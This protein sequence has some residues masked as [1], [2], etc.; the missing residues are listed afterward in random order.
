MTETRYCLKAITLDL[1]DTLWPSGPALAA[2]EERLHAWLEENAPAVAAALPPP[3]FMQLR[4]ALAAELPLIAHDFTALRHA[5]MTRALALHGEDSALADAGLEVFLA[6]RSEVELY[7]EVLEALERLSKRYRLVALSNGNA[8]IERAGVGRFF[9]AEVNARSAGVAKPDSRIFHAACETVGLPPAQVLHVGDHPDFDVR[10]AAR[11]GLRAA[12][13]NRP[14]AAWAGEAEE[15]HEFHEL[16]ALC[17]W[18][19]A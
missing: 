4:R 19:G 6:A 15:F 16:L 12:W 5:A 8:D 18:L 17:D 10:G 11:A 13:I 1:D 2:A 14:H 9:C 3:Q 7:P